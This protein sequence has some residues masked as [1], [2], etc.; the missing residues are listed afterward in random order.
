MATSTGLEVVSPSLAA[1]KS[2][3][4]AAV[5][6]CVAPYASQTSHGVST[7]AMPIPWAS[8]PER[9][10]S[11]R[12]VPLSGRNVYQSALFRSL[13]QPSGTVNVVRDPKR[14]VTVPAGRIPAPLS[15]ADGTNHAGYVGRADRDGAADG[16]VTA[17]ADGDGAAVGL[18]VGLIVGLGRAPPTPP[19]PGSRLYP[20]KAMATTATRAAAS[21]T[22]AFMAEPLQSRRQAGRCRCREMPAPTM[23]ITRSASRSDHRTTSGRG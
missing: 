15:S 10:Y 16:D 13:N 14:V 21:L 2:A 3:S 12:L 23:S 6:P 11:A 5:V 19:R 18:T 17:A 1:S 22:F 20:T 9:A 4:S 8:S 7:C